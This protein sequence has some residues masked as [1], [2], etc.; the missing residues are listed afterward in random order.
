MLD[1]TYVNRDEF[2][3]GMDYLERISN[4]TND[5]VRQFDRWKENIEKRV[6]DIEKGNYTPLRLSQWKSDMGSRLTAL[7]VGYTNICNDDKQ[8]DVQRNRN[9]PPVDAVSQRARAD[10]AYESIWEDAD[11]QDTSNQ[12][13]MPNPTQGND[14]SRPSCNE[15]TDTMTFSDEIA[16]ENPYSPLLQ[17]LPAGKQGVRSDG[18]NPRPQRGR[19]MRSRRGRQGAQQQK[20]QPSRDVRSSTE[21]NTAASKLMRTDGVRKQSKSVAQQPRKDEVGRG[22]A[23][24]ASAKKQATTV[25]PQA[26]KR[27]NASARRD[28]SEARATAGPSTRSDAKR[29]TNDQGKTKSGVNEVHEMGRAITSSMSKRG[30]KDMPATKKMH[31]TIDVSSSP[32]GEDD[33]TSAGR[34]DIGE[35]TDTDTTHDSQARGTTSANADVS[36]TSD[37]TDSYAGVA[38]KGQWL[39]PKSKKRKWGKKNVPVLRS[40]AEVNYKELYVQELD[41]TQCSGRDDFEDMVYAYC[42]NKGVKPIDLSMIPVR[43]TRLKAGCK[44]TINAA[45]YKQTSKDTFWPRGA[46]V[47]DWVT[48]PKKNDKESDDSDATDKE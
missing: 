29:P 5:K 32:S 6:A 20:T 4:E 25:A 17:D 43:G 30:E 40:S 27:V 35:A 37:S 39:K 7:E 15:G 38:A 33:D 12:I 22:L 14:G 26:T 41:Y 45:D 2:E 9:E 44:V 16:V 21:A 47:R 11:D 48:K 28:E 46:D 13:E 24:E 23:D 19:G 10:T 18:D 42:V 34:H 36:S 31:V 3:Y 1:I 8:P